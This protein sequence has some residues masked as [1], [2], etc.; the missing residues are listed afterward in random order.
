[1]LS[2][3]FARE[4]VGKRGRVRMVC[5]VPHKGLTQTVNHSQ[6]TVGNSSPALTVYCT[7]ESGSI[8]TTSSGIVCG[9]VPWY[10]DKR[11]RVAEC[12]K[13]GTVFGLHNRRQLWSC[14]QTWLGYKVG[15]H[16]E[17]ILLIRHGSLLEQTF[18][19]AHNQF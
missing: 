16:L 1:M 5:H 4:S 15:T 11:E 17:Q 6:Y 9:D 10:C 13:L 14:K 7:M 3:A 19:G 2:T 18:Y 12:Y 8:R